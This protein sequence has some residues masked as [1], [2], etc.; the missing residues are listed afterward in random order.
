VGTAESAVGGSK[1]VE[2]GDYQ[3]AITGLGTAGLDVVELTPTPLGVLTATGR[4]SYA[5][6]EAINEG[7]GISD[8][9]MKAGDE[10]V[11]SFM[12][13]GARKETA[14][15]L[16]AFSASISALNDFTALVFNPG[17]LNQRLASEFMSWVSQ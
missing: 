15:K 14:E 17:A 5:A 11:R 13:L 3:G 10:D 16:G 9:A 8:R 7:L 1:A 2:K 6:G 12:W 4:G